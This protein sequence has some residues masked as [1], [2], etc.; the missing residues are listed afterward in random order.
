MITSAGTAI[1]ANR[2]SLWFKDAV[3]YQLHV[4][5]F[6]DSNGDGVGDF[7]GLSQK[8]DYLQDL[9]VSALWLMPFCPSPLRDDGYDISD[10]RAIH[11][12]YGTLKDFRSFLKQAHQRGLRVITE[13]VLNHTSDQHPWFQ[14]ARRS[15]A[16]SPWRDWYVWSDTP[17]RFTE[18]RV[19]FQDFESSNWTWDPVA[20]AYF[21]HRFYS[22]QPDLNYD[23]P[24]V[25]KAIH[26]IVDFWF[27]LGVDGLRLDAD[28][29]PV[30]TGGDQ[31]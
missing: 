4:K 3:I 23:N 1:G 18:A 11:P 6:F 16:G 14:R 27:G 28:P 17:Q 2:N 10:Y 25:R 12:A 15:K 30:R 26:D 20:G 5:S 29:L 31:L 7:N 22:H 21:W 8:L 19:I 24:K 9:G 13:L